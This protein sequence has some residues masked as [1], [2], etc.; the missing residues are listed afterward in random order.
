MTDIFAKVMLDKVEFR[1][2]LYLGWF[3]ICKFHNLNR[4]YHIPGSVS[5]W[6]LLFNKMIHFLNLSLRSSRLIN[7]L[8]CRYEN[9]G[10]DYPIG[11]AFKLYWHFDRFYNNDNVT[12]F[13]SI[14][15]TT[16]LYFVTI[17]CSCV[18]LYMYFLK[19]HN[20]GRLMDIYWR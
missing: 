19:M 1:I 18:I 15:L 16:F 7:V 10:G 8:Y 13:V 5:S 20:N 11:D 12:L 4:T 2:T 6:F 9:R 3:Y 17:F 14:A